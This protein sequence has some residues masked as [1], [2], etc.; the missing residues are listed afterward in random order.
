VAWGSYC[1]QGSAWDSRKERTG[2]ALTGV[3]T[4]LAAA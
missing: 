1:L 2:A 4:P 3:A